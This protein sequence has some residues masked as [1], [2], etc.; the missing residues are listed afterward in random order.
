LNRD[1]FFITQGL[2]ANIN[3]LSRALRMTDK[4]ILLL[5]GEKIGAV[6]DQD[7]DQ[8]LDLDKERD[9]GRVTSSQRQTSH[10]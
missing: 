3:Q 4:E 10:A 8:D 1:T 6:Q 7:Q 5:R 9:A 2:A